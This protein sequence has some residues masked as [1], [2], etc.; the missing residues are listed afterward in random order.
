MG[1]S[2]NVRS[3]SPR[4]LKNQGANQD[5][6]L[7]HAYRWGTVREAPASTDAEL[8]GD[9][10][11]ISSRSTDLRH[12]NRWGLTSSAIAPATLR[13]ARP[14]ARSSDSTPTPPPVAV[15]LRERAARGAKSCDDELGDA[16]SGGPAC[17]DTSSRSRWW[18][19]IAAPLVLL[20]FVGSAAA[21]RKTQARV[22]STKAPLLAQLSLATAATARANEPAPAAKTA[23]PSSSADATP[24]SFAVSVSHEGH[25]PIDGGVL[26]LPRN[27]HPRDGGYDLVFHF[28]GDV[29]IVRESIERAGINAALAIVNWGVRSVPYRQ[30]YQETGRFEALQA[31]IYAGLAQRG[32][33]NVELRRMAL[34]AWSGG[35]GAIES[36]LE[37]R[38]APNAEADPLDAVIVLDGIHA[39][40][41]DDDPNRIAELS[42]LPFIRAAKAAAHDRIMFTLT[43]SEIDPKVYGST[44]RSAEVLLTAV[45]SKPQKSTL[46]R[47][48]HLRLRAASQSIGRDTELE[49]ITDTRVGMFRATGFRGITPEA[50]A[51]HL[52]QMAAIALPELA[53]RWVQAAPVRVHPVISD[54]TAKLP[55][56]DRPTPLPLGPTQDLAKGTAPAEDVPASAHATT[57]GAATP[58]DTKSKAV[59]GVVAHTGAGKASASAN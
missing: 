37:N 3:K 38:L 6:G 11:P 26:L 48:E 50:H 33:R 5:R 18:A 45:G 27:F 49:P 46:P 19:W 43:H 23:T 17:D 24:G 4:Q 36:I 14:S 32:F 8:D 57:T 22:P 42:I 41:V 35:Y 10:E 13:S 31:Q 55:R 44:T 28:H 2:S 7:A 51:A 9:D 34:M 39:G 47:P 30:V 16:K 1:K 21:W 56:S 15:T 40:F 54:G 59:T 52:L 53:L 20:A 29:Q 25:V 58:S 12:A